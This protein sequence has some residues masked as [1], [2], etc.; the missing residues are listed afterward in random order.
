M[1]ISSCLDKL[2]L[3]INNEQKYMWI[4]YIKCLMWTRKFRERSIYWKRYDTILHSVLMDYNL[5]L[6]KYNDVSNK[7][8]CT[9]FASKLCM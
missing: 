1:L 5:H 4:M 6:T 9:F 8:V 7:Y 3:T 2:L